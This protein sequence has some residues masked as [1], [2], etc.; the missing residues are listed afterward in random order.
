[1]RRFALPFVIVSLSVPSYSK[2]PGTSGGEMQEPPA[3][4]FA[5]FGTSRPKAAA[6]FDHIDSAAKARYPGHAVHW[7]FTSGRIVRMIRKRGG[8]A[9]T[10]P[11]VIDELARSGVTSVAFQS[12]HVV[13]GQ[14]DAELRGTD[15]G[16]LSAACGAPLL[17]SEADIDR[18]ILALGPS[19]RPGVP[20]VVVCHGNSRYP[21][22]N[23]R[24]IELAGKLRP[25]H[26]N[27]YVCS[28]EGEPGTDRLREAI[29][30]ARA[31]GA[32]HFIP[33]M[34]VAG[35]HIM[36]DVMGDGPGSWKSIIGA[37]E[38][39]VSKPLGYNDAIL[40][41][42]FSHLDDALESLETA[43]AAAR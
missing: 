16:G 33:L 35:V 30:A 3:I 8:R 25:R 19:I 7:A 37:P 29:P 17:G 34:I 41:I 42:Y 14:K 27:V 43:A 40:E 21:E 20:N 11:E 32:V 26:R 31:A 23:R 13:P 1:M 6:V 24:L 38:A 4:V 39:T 9:K 28:V 22:Y 18:A 15:T 36:D 10:L 5:A 2:A 12:L